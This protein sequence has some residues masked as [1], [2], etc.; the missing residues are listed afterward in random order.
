[1]PRNP[2]DIRIKPVKM[3]GL[4]PFKKKTKRTLGTR[5]KQILYRRAKGKCEACGKKIDYDEMQ[6][7][8]KRAYSKGGAT[9]LAN[10]ACLCYRCN[11]LQGTGSLAT[12][13]KKLAGTYG[14]RTKKSTKKKSTKRKRSSKGNYWIN[15]IT[16]KKEK[17][18]SPFGF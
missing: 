13:K 14:K 16:G 2:W 4:S 11:K 12:L 1:M 6:V 17:I 8:H 9:T 10:S 18:K 3:P 7:G 15:P 5:D